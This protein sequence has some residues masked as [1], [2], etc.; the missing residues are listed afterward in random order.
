MKAIMTL[1]TG[2]FMCGTMRAP[3][4]VTTAGSAKE[5]RKRFLSRSRLADFPTKWSFLISTLARILEQK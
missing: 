2:Q 5:A 3:L 1:F 4:M